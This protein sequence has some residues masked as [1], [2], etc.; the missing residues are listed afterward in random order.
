MKI[1]LIGANGFVGTRLVECFHL[2]F[3]PE[4]VAIVRRPSALALPA[5]FAVEMRVA[6]ALDPAALA[7]AL[8][9]CDA[10]VHAALGDPA[11]IARMPLALCQAAASAGVDRIVYLSSASVHG[12][13][14]PRGTDESSPLHQ[15]HSLE[16]NNAK[17]FAERHFFAECRRLGLAGY[18]LRPG[19][20]FGPR[21]RWITNLAVELYEGRA[22]LFQGGRGICNSIYIDNLIAAIRACLVAPDAAGQPF[23]V[24]DAEQVTWRDF[25][26]AAAHELDVPERRIHALDRLPVFSRS[27]RERIERAVATPLAQRALPAVPFTLKRRTKALLAAWSPAPAADSWA[28]SPAPAPVVTEEMALLQQCAWKLPSTRATTLLGYEPPVRFAEGMRR[29][30]SWWRFSR[31]ELSAAPEP[32]RTA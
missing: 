24:G 3:G 22:W 6:D 1:A 29:S 13:N 12:Q 18:A 11:Q 16:Y 10:V 26:L 8:A 20:V 15:R 5:R 25:Y 21:S 27:W 28:D 2:D 31:G 19:V 4:I 7:A 17:V 32:S 9:G 23:L 14:P 30:L